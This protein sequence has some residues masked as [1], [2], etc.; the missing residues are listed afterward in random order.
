MVFSIWRECLGRGLL[1]RILG[2]TV[3]AG[4]GNAGVNLGMNVAVSSISRPGTI[5]SLYN[6]A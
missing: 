5:P 3:F 6:G 1:I 4:V 2:V